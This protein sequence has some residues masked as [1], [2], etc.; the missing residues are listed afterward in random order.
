M[1]RNTLIAA[2]LVVAVAAGSARA[3]VRGQVVNTRHNLSP[4][5]TGTI[6]ATNA[7]DVQICI[8]CHTPHNAVLGNVYTGNQLI[9]LWNHA[10]TG[11]AFTMYTSSTM[12]STPTA[13]PTSVTKACL[14]CH[15]GTVAV[16][17]LNWTY[18]YGYN[19]TI[20]MAGVNA[21]GQIPSTSGAY[22]GT[23]LSNDHPVTMTYNTALSVTDV[24]LRDPSTA[25]VPANNPQAGQLVQTAMLVSDTVQCSSCH[26]VHGVDPTFT[27]VAPRT[28]ATFVPLM[29]VS[30][31][32]S[33]L[34]TTC[35]VK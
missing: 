28:A 1:K 31:Y 14:S 23:D 4:T 16:G 22:L 24:G 6:K 7:L 5:G 32:Q 19:T 10:T 15:D 34:C 26:V 20:A 25:T 11:A 21:N 2:L 8:F 13:A 35:H 9:P 3:G 27:F 29:R 18:D 12:D 30:K 17:A 33:E